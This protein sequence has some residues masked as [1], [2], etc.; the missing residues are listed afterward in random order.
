MYV[1]KLN[2]VTM[3]LIIHFQT[4]FQTIL[5]VLTITSIPNF[6]FLLSMVHCFWTS[7]GK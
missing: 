6:T 5:G 4:A 2:I 7:K 3:F 1:S